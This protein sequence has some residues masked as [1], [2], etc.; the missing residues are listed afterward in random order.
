[1]ERR[2]STN[3]RRR[4]KCAREGIKRGKINTKLD[5][6]GQVKTYYN[7]SFV[8]VSSHIRAGRGKFIQF[9]AS[10]CWFKLL[11]TDP[12]QLTLGIFIHITIL[13]MKV[14]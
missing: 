7:I 10:Q 4:W 8:V 14:S 12:E 5:F 11:E 2:E 9:N 6:R 13:K 3:Q 1:M